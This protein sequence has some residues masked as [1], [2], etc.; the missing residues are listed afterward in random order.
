MRFST[1]SFECILIM[2]AID[3]D[4]FAKK[5]SRAIL[6]IVKSMRVT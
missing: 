1:V 5:K 4:L 2:D 6:A 3:S